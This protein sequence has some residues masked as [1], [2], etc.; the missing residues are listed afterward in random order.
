MQVLVRWRPLV[1]ALGIVLTVGPPAL[2]QTGL[3]E[4][5]GTVVDQSGPRCRA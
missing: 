5:R 4:I 2:T 1:M 3:A